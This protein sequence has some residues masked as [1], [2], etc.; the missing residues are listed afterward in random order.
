MSR[1]IDGYVSAAAGPHWPA[2]RSFVRNSVT[3]Y[4]PATVGVARHY[5]VAVAHL[6]L[7]SWQTAGLGLNSAVVFQHSNVERFIYETMRHRNATYRHQTAQRLNLLVTHFTGTE[8]PQLKHK[9]GQLARPY[10]DKELVNFRSSAARRSTTERRTNAHVLLGLG[11][12]AGLRAEEVAE[13][14][15]ADIVVDNGVTLVH[16]PGKHARTVPVHTTWTTTVKRGVDG[17]PEDDFAFTGYR[18]PA[19]RARVVHQFGIDDP[20]E[21]TPSTTRLR[22]TWIVNLLSSGVP[23]NRVLQLAGVLETVSLAP[24]VRAMTLQPLAEHLDLIIGR[25]VN[26]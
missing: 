10:N 15:V 11:A 5:L 20:T 22:A 18:R 16:V 12:G 3:A 1:V 14:K 7:W 9:T 4:A 17:R 26:R 8:T 24:Y 2:I 25:Q 21:D 23:V 6:A 13:V 19:Y